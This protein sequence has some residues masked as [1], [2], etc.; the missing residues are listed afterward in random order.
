MP[1][2]RKKPV[3]IEAVQF[4]R[5]EQPHELAADVVAG[6]V[7]YTEDDTMLIATLEGTMEARRLDYQGSQG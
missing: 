1:K 5:G 2:F 3:V 4:R 6:R 7:R